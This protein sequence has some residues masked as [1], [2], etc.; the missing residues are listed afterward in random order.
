MKWNPLPTKPF[1]AKDWNDQL[2]SLFAEV[3]LESPAEVEFTNMETVTITTRGTR[4]RGV[5]VWF[6][7]EV[8]GKYYREDERILTLRQEPGVIFIEFNHSAK[9]KVVVT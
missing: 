6:L 4:L 5:E 8:D 1:N 9:G 3:D 2:T 7:N